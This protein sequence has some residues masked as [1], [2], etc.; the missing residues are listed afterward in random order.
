MQVVD[1]DEFAKELMGSSHCGAKWADDMLTMI[2]E[3]RLRNFRWCIETVV[4][5]NI[6]GDIIECGVWRGGACIYAKT[7]VDALGSSKRVFV[8]DS[9][10]GFPV[11]KYNWDKGADFLDEPA[12]KVSLEEVKR[13]FQKFGVLDESVIFVEGFFSETLHRLDGPFAVIRLDGD[14]FESTVD[15]LMGLYEKLSIGGYMIIDDYGLECCHQAV[16]QFRELNK[17]YD[18]IIPIDEFGVYWR[19]GSNTH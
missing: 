6:E 15:G 7:V 2:G 14:L 8:A 11:P 3:V 9:F 5:E 13:N 4:R 18:Q 17:I 1:L 19:K 16:S 12:L 10:R